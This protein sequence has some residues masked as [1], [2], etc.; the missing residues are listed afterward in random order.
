M[1]PVVLESDELKGKRVLV[2]HGDAD[3]HVSLKSVEKGIEALRRAGADVTVHRD[4]AGTHFLLFARTEEV[5]E[6]LG[7]WMKG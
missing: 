1:E 5:F 4:P 7:E 6:Q 2:I 3:K